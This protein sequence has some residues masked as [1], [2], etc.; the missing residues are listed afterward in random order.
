MQ[1]A[2][3]DQTDEQHIEIEDEF[4]LALEAGVEDESA[5]E[6]TSATS[7]SITSYGADYPVDTLVKRMK[8]EAVLYPTFPT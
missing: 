4:E 2:P 7:F 3:M 8:G 6:A 1:A 5:E